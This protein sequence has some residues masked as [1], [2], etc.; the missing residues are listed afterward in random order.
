MPHQDFLL[1]LLSDEIA[2]RDSA[3]VTL[4]AAQPRASPDQPRS[5]RSAFRPSG[6]TG[7]A[8]QG[9]LAAPKEA[10]DLRS[11]GHFPLGET[12][13]NA[14]PPPAFSTRRWW[15]PTIPAG[16]PGRDATSRP[17]PGRYLAERE[18]IALGCTSLARDGTALTPSSTRQVVNIH[19]LD[20]LKS[21]I[22]YTV[23]NRSARWDLG[24]GA[25]GDRR[26][27]RDPAT[28]MPSRS[29]TETDA[30]QPSLPH[31]TAVSRIIAG[32]RR[33]R[34]NRPRHPHPFQ[35]RRPHATAG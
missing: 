3:A 35:F 1:L 7:S 15:P 13:E 31:R 28:R 11:S 32:R 26:P 27:C 30:G 18:T 24:G 12:T 10:I 25:L 6:S 23:L 17:R 22:T 8:G 20:F 33:G 2:R 29:T 14:P 16:T 19:P 34:S 21:P 9:M 4:R 5:Q